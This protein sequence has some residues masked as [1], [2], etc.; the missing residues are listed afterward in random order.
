MKPACSALLLGLLLPLSA[1]ADW[2]Y[3]ISGS[4]TGLYGYSDM[5]KRFRADERHSQGTGDFHLNTAVIYTYNDDYGASLNADFMGGIDHNLK[6]YS[7]GSWGEEIYGIFDAPAGRLMLGQTA[8]VGAQFHQGAPMVGPLGL[9]DSRIVDFIANPNWTR[10]KKVASFATLN[11]TSPNTD[12]TAPKISYI[13][14][15][16]YNTLLGFSYIPDSYSRTGL[17][18]KFAHYA[19][20]DGYVGSL[21]HNLD[22]GW[23]DLS[24]SVSYAEYHDNDKEFF[25]G[26][27]LRR[28]GWTVGGSW[29]KTYIDGDDKRRPSS[30]ERTP[31]LFDNYREGYA[32][33]IGVGYEIG[34]YQVSLGYFDAKAERTKN[35][36]R[37]V[38]LSNEYQLNKW[39]DI[40]LTGAYA[41]FDGATEAVAENRTGYAVVAGARLNF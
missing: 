26:M 24:A 35:R 7:Q 14:P 15:Q 23:G 8:N 2:D 40:Y 12:G 4:A 29:R 6:N 9:N 5:E 1:H 19:K 13:T 36:S 20:K 18:N 21:Y 31:E 17:V 3:K 38:M 41:K 37:I 22:L 16:F 25:A 32:W 28:G 30:A 39:L 34:P 27:Q 33:D 10:T 11:S